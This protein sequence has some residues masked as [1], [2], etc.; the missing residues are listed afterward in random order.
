MAHGLAVVGKAYQNCLAIR[1][2]T[3]FL[4]KLQLDDGGWG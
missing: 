2:T 1:K 3:D 4:V